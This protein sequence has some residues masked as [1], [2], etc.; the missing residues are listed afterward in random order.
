MSKSDF[1]HK[2]V[3]M[4]MMDKKVLTFLF[5][6]FV[7]GTDFIYLLHHC[8]LG[9]IRIRISKKNRQHSGQRKKYKRTSNDSLH[10]KTHNTLDSYLM[11]L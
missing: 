6:I 10:S 4:V 5:N 11:L 8:S 2:L 7:F 9:V 3:S 1:I